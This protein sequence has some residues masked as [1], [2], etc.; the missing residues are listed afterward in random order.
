MPAKRTSLHT[1]HRL[2]IPELNKPEAAHNRVYKVE[3]VVELLDRPSP[4]WTPHIE[5]KKI[6]FITS[7]SLFFPLHLSSILLPSFHIYFVLFFLS[8]ISQNISCLFLFTVMPFCFIR[9]ICLLDIFKFSSTPWLFT[10]SK[11]IFLY[12]LDQFQPLIWEFS[13]ENRLIIFLASQ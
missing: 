5:E 8:L 9:Q 6:T 7:Q 11:N 1:N 4:E 13:T 12:F 3:E 10:N 2:E